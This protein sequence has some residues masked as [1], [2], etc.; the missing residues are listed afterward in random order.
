MDDQIEN[1]GGASAEMQM[2]YHINFGEP[3]VGDGAQLVAPVR[4][5]A[6]NRYHVGDRWRVRHGRGHPSA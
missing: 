5:V 6:P 2:L 1:Y 3:L 4:E